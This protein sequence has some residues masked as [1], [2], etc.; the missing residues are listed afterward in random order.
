MPKIFKF[1]FDPFDIAGIT[2]KPR[3]ETKDAILEEVSNFVLESVLSDVGEAKSPVTGRGWAALNKDYIK[4]KKGQGARP[5]ANLEL[6][7]DMLDKLVVKPKGSKLALFVSDPAQ[8]GKVDG[9]NHLSGKTPKLP[10]RQFIPEE[11][12]KFSKEIM[13]GIKGIVK[14]ALDES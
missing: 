12:G 2:K 5:I 4:T 8:Q 13:K 10:R 1:E 14:D 9:H 7:G 3:G 6:S 11:D